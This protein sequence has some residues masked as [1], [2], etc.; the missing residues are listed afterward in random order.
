VRGRVNA[1]FITN[2]DDRAAQPWELE[3]AAAF[4][5]FEHRRARVGGSPENQPSR[6]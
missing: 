6:R 4:E 2:T 3:P 1:D 5:I